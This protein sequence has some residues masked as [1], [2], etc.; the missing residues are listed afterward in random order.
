VFASLTAEADDQAACRLAV[1]AFKYTSVDIA[2]FAIRAASGAALRNVAGAQIRLAGIVLATFVKCTT[3]AGSQSAHRPTARAFGDTLSDFTTMA[4]RAASGATALR[5]ATGAKIGN[6][7]NTCV[8]LATFA[9]D[10][11]FSST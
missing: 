6:I 4:R 3:E 5:K 11:A 1:R 9:G 10:A 7:G 8:A 2:T